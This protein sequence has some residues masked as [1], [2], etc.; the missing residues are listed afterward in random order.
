MGT[1]N[2]DRVPIRVRRAKCETVGQMI[3][4][5]WDVQSK[6]P[7]CHLEMDVDLNLVAMVRGP[8]FS[9]WNKKP[10]CRRRLCNGRVRFWARSPDMSWH[11]ELAADDRDPL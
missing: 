8:G 5:R 1:R 3:A 10:R 6:C 7:V 4:Q 2:P 11:E 9:L